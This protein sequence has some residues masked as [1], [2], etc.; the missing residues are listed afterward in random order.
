MF[1]Y[2]S[3]SYLLEI[4]ELQS[5]LKFKIKEELS[6]NIDDSIS[7][8]YIIGHVLSCVGCDLVAVDDSRQRNSSF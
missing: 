5:R 8:L 4:N 2:I 1:V 6:H 3:I 7:N